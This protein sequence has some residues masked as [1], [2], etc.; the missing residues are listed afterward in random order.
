[1][2]YLGIVTSSH[3]WIGFKSS[4]SHSGVSYVGTPIFIERWKKN[5]KRD[6]R[7]DGGRDSKRESGKK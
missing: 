6:R 3:S 1:M 2:N 4:Q 7:K 5:S